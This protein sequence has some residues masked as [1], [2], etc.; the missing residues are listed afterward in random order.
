MPKSHKTHSLIV[1]M[2][3]FAP[4]YSA[5]ETHQGAAGEEKRNLDNMMPQDRELYEMAKA[6]LETLEKKSKSG[7]GGK[8]KGAAVY[9]HVIYPGESA[10]RNSL[11]AALEFMN[12]KGCSKDNLKNLAVNITG[13]GNPSTIGTKSDLSLDPDG[14]TGLS[15]MI[16]DYLAAS[17]SKKTALSFYI[18]SCNSGYVSYSE[19]EEEG[20]D[21]RPKKVT[22]EARVK[23]KVLDKSY[24]GRFFNGVMRAIEDDG[25]EKVE[26]SV[27]GFRG[28]IG[29]D[30][31]GK[32]RVS[33]RRD[34]S[35]VGDIIGPDRVRFIISSTNTLDG[36]VEVVL[37]QDYRFKVHGV[38]KSLTAQEGIDAKIGI[39]PSSL[40]SAEEKPR[41]EVLTEA[42]AALTDFEAPSREEM[43]SGVNLAMML[44]A[45]QRV[46]FL[47]MKK[48]E[49]MAS[50]IRRKELEVFES[51]YGKDV[52][53]FLSHNADWFEMWKIREDKRDEM[54]EF[55]QG[56]DD[57]E[58][59]WQM[60]ETF[61]PLEFILRSEL[62]FEEM[63]E[64]FSDN[65]M[66]IMSW[67]Q[68]N[69]FDLV[70]IYRTD[71]DLF[72]ALDDDDTEVL[73]YETD[74]IEETIEEYRRQKSE[75]P[76]TNPFDIF[77]AAI[78]RKM[79]ID[80]GSDEEG[81]S[82]VSEDDVVL[83]PPPIATT[84]VSTKKAF[85]TVVAKHR[86][87]ESE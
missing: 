13:H 6:D 58:K 76:D 10:G 43:I 82:D 77:Q 85:R 60:A 50:Q 44:S 71:K 40:V 73:I 54:V 46:H 62:S 26:V 63:A 65:L 49:E 55:L 19:A 70:E 28:Y 78:N 27:S 81:L 5:S 3:P 52:V 37:P 14:M 2:L 18:L 47:E 74:K 69:F 39:M 32:M 9:P 64:V 66:E 20:E 1:V 21:K 33:A 36:D 24:A 31:K 4:R 48:Q 30:N 23:R 22:D 34:S 7:F 8:F 25:E 56:F 42:V 51:V 87:Y 68:I 57:I 61:T 80:N 84:V 67:G 72:D 15:T 45:E 86:G 16:Y 79:G 12:K 53:D 83:S 29:H 11:N 59:F 75:D 35:G 17:I 38:E 41:E